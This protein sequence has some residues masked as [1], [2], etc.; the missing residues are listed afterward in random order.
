MVKFKSIQQN[1]YPL[2]GIGISYYDLEQLLLG[3][4]LYS[5]G[6]KTDGIPDFLM[7][8]GETNDE[9][10]IDLSS[11]MHQGTKIIERDLCAAATSHQEMDTVLEKS[12]DS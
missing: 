3:N 8:L 1:G 10:E 5:K 12:N 7:F 2:V 11:F 6:N 9:M 4:P